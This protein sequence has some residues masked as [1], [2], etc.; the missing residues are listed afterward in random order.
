MMEYPTMLQM[1]VEKQ[2]GKSNVG[3]TSYFWP[4][5]FLLVFFRWTRKVICWT[6]V[7][8]GFCHCHLFCC[9]KFFWSGTQF[10]L[11]CTVEKERKRASGSG[12]QTNYT[13]EACFGKLKICWYTLLLRPIRIPYIQEKVSLSN[14]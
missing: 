2:G 9:L 4:R 7:L 6:W 3:Q 10:L 8:S 14:L 12:F 13:E 11:S 1:R 5:T